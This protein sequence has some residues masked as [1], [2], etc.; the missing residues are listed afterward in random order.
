LYRAAD[1]L[2]VD[3]NVAIIPLW[4]S[5]RVMM[6]SPPNAFTAS[7]IRVS[8]VATITLSSDRQRAARS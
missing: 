4:W 8:S 5:A 3:D 7:A 2:I 1:K 6:N